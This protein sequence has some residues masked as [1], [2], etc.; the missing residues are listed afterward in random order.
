M[1]RAREF[2]P[3]ITLNKAMDVFWQKGYANTSIDDLVTA[4]GVNRYG[5]YGEFKSKHSLFLAC[6]DHYQ[7]EIVEMAFGV[8]E[9][10]DASLPNIRAYFNMVT[11]P[12]PAGRGDMGCLMINTA[13]DIAAHDKR[14]AKKVE[15]YFARLQSGFRKALA[16]AKASGE[17]PAHVD[18]EQMADFL[19]GVVQ[20]LS[21]M[22]RSRA[23]PKMIANV[24]ATALRSLD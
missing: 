5:L 24:V 11:G 17:L 4:T 6:L 18:V 20:G 12:A 16:N 10:P 7:N 13:N 8:V 2:D 1:P 23:Q 9:Q 19:I 22:V 3:A 14:A 15:K 21:V